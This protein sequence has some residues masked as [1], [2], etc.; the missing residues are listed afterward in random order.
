MP[1]IKPT[2]ERVT[3]ENINLIQEFSKR[4]PEVDISGLKSYDELIAEGVIINE[5]GPN[6]FELIYPN[7]RREISTSLGSSNAPTIEG[8]FDALVIE[9]ERVKKEEEK[10]VLEREEE[11]RRREEEQRLRN[12]EWAKKFPNLYNP[13]GT[14]KK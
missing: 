4:N 9:K 14:R 6:D 13:D 5:I 12:I 2:S 1:K 11:K 10:R 3:N 7:G 8:R